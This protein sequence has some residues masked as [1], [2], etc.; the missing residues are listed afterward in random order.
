[1]NS[2]KDFRGRKVLRVPYKSEPARPVG[3][4]QYRFLTAPM[5]IYLSAPY[6]VLVDA[7]AVHVFGGGT[8]SRLKGVFLYCACSRIE[9]DNCY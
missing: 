6:E 3:R 9:S 4:Y 2:E 5:K 7:G 1:M 8:T